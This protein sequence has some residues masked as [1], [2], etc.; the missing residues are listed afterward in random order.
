M[1]KDFYII[2]FSI[3]FPIIFGV[4]AAF[5]LIIGMRGIIK[6]RPFLLSNRWMLAM[7]F[8]IF[9]PNI[10]LPFIMPASTPSFIK[11]FNPA[12][13]SVLL[14]MMCIILK[15]YSAFGVTDNTFRNALLQSLQK[16][17]LPYEETLSAIHLTSVEVDLQVSVQSWV[18][19]GL[20][21]VKQRGHSPLL[22]NIVLAMNEHFQLSNT[23]AK[24]L[25]C[26]FY[27]IVGVLMAAAGIGMAVL[28]QQFE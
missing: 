19:S 11:W 3:V 1:D 28:F 13:F 2:L 9:V 24:L 4:I 14:V 21:K 25:T 27:V 7:M 15:G 22:A 12:M 17:E 8:I 16:L 23:T 20:I 5:F 26:I 6:R 10:F 18:G